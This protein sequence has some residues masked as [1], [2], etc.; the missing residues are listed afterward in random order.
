MQE[1]ND[2]ILANAL[3]GCYLDNGST[4]EMAQV[5]D[6]HNVT[7]NESEFYAAAD[8]AMGW[9]ETGEN[10]DQLTPE[11]AQK[12]VDSGITF[13]VQE[14][15]AIPG[16]DISSDGDGGFWVSDALMNKIGTIPH[17]ERSIDYK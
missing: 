12:L 13:L 16:K 17:Q 3:L 5:C 8:K 4:D 14:L 2:I 6:R 9:L 11:N 1:D 10:L 15:G 7:I